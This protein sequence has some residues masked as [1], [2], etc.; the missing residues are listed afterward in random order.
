MNPNISIVIESLNQCSLSL[1]K[2]VESE[3]T[4][5][6][7][8]THSP[9]QMMERTSNNI[10][11]P[12]RPWI[13]GGGTA[14]AVGT[15][16]A[17]FTNHWW[18]YVIGG[19]GIV[20]LCIGAGQRNNSNASRN[21]NETNRLK[22]SFNALDFCDKIIELTKSIENKWR[23][24]VEYSKDI[25]QRAIHN[26]ALS[27]PEQEKLL[28]DTFSTHRINFDYD[29]YIGKLST[30]VSFEYAKQVIESFGKELQNSIR[31]V[32]SEQIKIYSSIGEN[33]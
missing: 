6:V 31:K 8:I 10:S 12:E 1:C 26:S 5:M 19:C 25:V 28:S 20:S 7:Q 3:V 17:I 32:A 23:E 16:L 13:V 30:G 24:K 9:I 21:H 29:S 27:Q 22:P 33:F 15:I 4:K 11:N 18:S 2:E 14:L